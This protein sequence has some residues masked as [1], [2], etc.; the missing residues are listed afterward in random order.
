MTEVHESSSYLWVEVFVDEFLTT[1]LPLLIWSH[2]VLRLQKHTKMT[3]SYYRNSVLMGE[4][5]AVSE[6]S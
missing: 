1:L 3:V 4:N 5:V 2:L 6:S